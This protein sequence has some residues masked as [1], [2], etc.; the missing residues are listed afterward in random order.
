MALRLPASR[1]HRAALAIL[2]LTVGQLAL[3]VL[4]PDLPQFE[5]KAFG[6]RLVFYPLLMLAVPAVWWLVRRR[7]GGTRPAVGRLRV[8]HVAVPRRR[9]GQYARPLR[10]ALVVGRS[11]PP[12][13]LV[14]A[15]PRRGAAAATRARGASLGARRCWSAASARSSRS[16]GSSASGTRSSA[17][18]PRSTRPTRT[19]SATRRSGRSA[20]S[21]PASRSCGAGSA[22][23]GRPV[24]E[25]R[26]SGARRRR[27][28]RRAVR[29]AR[30]A[31]GGARGGRRCARRIR[32]AASG[33]R[34]CR[35]SPSRSPA[36][37][38]P[39]P[40]R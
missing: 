17:T 22:P 13:Q 3:A 23:T 34:C 30:S 40:R 6:A 18:A 37:R 26:A 35:A 32:A 1:A 28:P 21:W 7:T 27:A 33:C 39:R 24:G 11:Q 29:R 8:A 36:R 10:H 5:G 9:H 31:A 25:G 20:G 2:A 4:A 16:P 15:L 38:A 19:R 12:R 14:P